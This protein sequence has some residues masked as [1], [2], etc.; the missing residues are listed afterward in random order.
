L[1][2]LTL[3]LGFLFLESPRSLFATLFLLFEG[4]Y[5]IVQIL[6]L[7]DIPADVS[8]LEPLL[9]VGMDQ[10]LFE[11]IREE[12]VGLVLLLEH[13][14]LKLDL[15]VA[16]LLTINFLLKSLFVQGLFKEAAFKDIHRFLQIAHYS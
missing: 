5:L 1:H 12:H 10:L 14:H 4:V 8:F 11:L 9:L 6:N 3:C 13:L 15:L 16:V 2:G 7:L